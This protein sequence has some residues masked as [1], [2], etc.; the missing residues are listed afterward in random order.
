[1]LW[2]VAFLALV[3]GLVLADSSDT[4]EP[5]GLRLTMSAATERI[6]LPRTHAPIV[7]SVDTLSSRIW[8]R[9]SRKD[10]PAA[11]VARIAGHLGMLCPRAEVKN[12]AVEITCRSRRIEAQI[13]PEGKLSYLDINELR[14]L[15]WRAGPD[16]PPSYYYDPW[17]TGLGQSC[18]GQS[19]AVKGECE[20]KEGHVLQAAAHFRAALDTNNRQMACVRLGDLAIGIGD[21][22]TGAGWYR[23]AGSFGVFGRIADARLCELDGKCLASTEQVLRTFDWT[24]FP[25]PLRAESLVRA[26]RAEVYMGRSRAAI[27]IIARQAREHGIASICREGGEIL[28]RR[29]LLEAMRD[30]RATEPSTALPATTRTVKANITSTVTSSQA[31]SPPPLDPAERDYLEEVLEAYLAIPSW[32]KGPLAIELVQAAAPMAARLGAHAFGGNLLASVAPEVPDALL[33][34]HLLLA[35][36]TFLGGENWARARVV[37]EY[38]RSRLGPKSLKG[39]RWTAVLH[40]LEVRSEEEDVSSSVR[41]AIEAELGTTLSE[42]T[43][44]RRVLTQAQ[45][46]LGSAREAQGSQARSQDSARDVTKRP[47]AANL[48]SNLDAE[49]GK[50]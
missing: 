20:L 38:A 39:A 36:E 40:A 32:E 43:N 25:E 22:I 33:S 42:L 37:A 21:P 10:S 35:T 17:R 28:C 1:V 26:A 45:S 7:L 5:R 31:A 46:L 11:L 4:V 47:S 27:H 34:E 18:P 29:L 24:G 12:D 41:A 13:T 16:A 23:R 50:R 15:P 6:P 30:V 14:G 48:G 3:P 44:A 19:E 49:Q 9:P 8:L 2:T